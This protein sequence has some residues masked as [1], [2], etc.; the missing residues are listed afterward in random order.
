M[1]ANVG[2]WSPDLML[3]WSIYLSIVVIRKRVRK[4]EFQLIFFPPLRKDN[5]RLLINDQKK[6]DNKVM[7]LIS[8]V[9][10]HYICKENQS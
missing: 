3:S 6:Q 1:A 4:W 10:I 8:F 9:N 5:N 7:I 2:E